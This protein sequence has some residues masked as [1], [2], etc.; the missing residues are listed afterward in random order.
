MIKNKTIFKRALSWMGTLAIIV[1]S[2]LSY[3]QDPVTVR[4]LAVHYAGNIQYSYQVSNQTRARSIVSVSIGNRGVQ[5]PDPVYSTNAQPELSIYPAGSYWERQPDQGD[6][7]NVTL[8]LGG[9]YTSPPGWTAEILEYEESGNFSI[10]WDRNVQT[11]RGILPGQTFNFGVTV[12][13]NDDPRSAYTMSDPAYLNGHFTVGFTHSTATDEGPA[14]WVYTGPIM[15][16]DTTP[17]TLTVSLSP[18]TLWPPNDKLV[19]VTAAITVKDDYDPAPEIQLVSITA[20]EVLDKDDIKGALPGTDSRQF[21]LKAEREGKNKA[22][23]IYTVTYS[24]TDASGNKA[25]ASATVTVP[26]DQGK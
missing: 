18:A 7:H 1:A 23:R 5:P 22:G 10:D 16:I 6:S 26:H 8:R 25:T 15:P 13:L 2:P 4:A 14:F 17:P 9:T 19:S 20:N 12:P 3:A 24:A 21:M 11:D